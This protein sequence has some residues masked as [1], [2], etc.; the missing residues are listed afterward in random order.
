MTTYRPSGELIL[1]GQRFPTDAPIVNFTEGPRWD[2]TSELCVPTL[3][4]PAPPCTVDAR[5]KHVP[6]GKLPFGPYTQRYST[7]P[8]LRGYGNGF[9]A[10]LA[11]VQQAITQFV[12]HHDGCNSADMCFSVLQNERGLSVHFLIDNDG[13]IYQTIDLALMAYHAS[14]WNC[15]SI[16]VELCNRGDAKREPHYYDGGR[17]GP[18]RDVRPCR[19]NDSTL[20]AFDYTPAQYDA[21]TRLARALARLLPNL[22][23]DYPQASPGE[24][25]W[26]TLPHADSLAFRGYIGHYHLWDQKWDPGPFD[27]RA[28]CSKLRGAACFP[29]APRPAKT[30]ATT[31]EPPQVPD[32]ADQLRRDADAL[33]AANEQRAD[34]GFF[35]VGPW[36]ESRL[37]HGGV[38]LVA[39]AGDPI[40]APFAG[41]LVAARL[42]ATSSIGSTSFVL[43]RHEL[44]VAPPRHGTAGARARFY[45]LYMHVGDPAR[46]GMRAGETLLLDEPV[47][48]GAVIA[49]VGVAGPGELAR[50]QLHVEVFATRDLFADAP[51]SPWTVVDGTAGGRFCDAPEI[52]AAI[53]ADGD[54]TL[55]HHELVDFYRGAGAQQLHYVVTQHVSEWT[56]E[57]SW[58][59]ALRVPKD[60]RHLA[61]AELDRLV[62]DQIEPG[63]WWDARVAAHCGLPSDGVVFHYHPVSFLAWV[64]QQLA[65]AAAAAGARAVDAA[66]ATVVPAGITDDLGDVTGASMRGGDSA[67]A[68][69]CDQLTLDDLEDGFDAPCTQP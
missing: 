54:G 42:G 16:G 32:D 18:R 53:D 33:Y 64:N 29:L 45:S 60:F 7:R 47:E 55:S 51:R 50:A 1:A 14:E 25:S 57:P 46:P 27:F 19:I 36:G 22:P 21:L 58:R 6:Y 26:R 31:P 11:A 41:R 38:H 30:A 5:G 15:A 17:F 12:I 40:Y 3:T 13:T 24:Q 67:A 65:D 69:P 44:A 39:R 4:D 23:Q 68:D 8:A 20:L 59:D 35:P 10:P 9:T 28:F 66:L 52:D 49:R 43:L 62:A 63:L 37:W 61:A 56:A 2:A 34:G 48:A